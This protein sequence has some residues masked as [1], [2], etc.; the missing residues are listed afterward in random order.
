LHS[1][2]GLFLIDGNKIKEFNSDCF[3]GDVVHGF[4]YGA[5]VAF[6]DL[7]VDDVFVNDGVF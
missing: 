1:F 2:A 4:V 6:T 5:V 7:L 3:L